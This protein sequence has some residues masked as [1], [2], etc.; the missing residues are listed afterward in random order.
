MTLNTLA[1]ENGERTD[2]DEVQGYHLPG[3]GNIIEQYDSSSDS[4]VLLANSKTTALASAYFAGDG[5]NSTALDLQ[6]GNSGNYSFDGA[7]YASNSPASLQ[8]H[9][10]GTVIASFIVKGL[11]MNGG[12]NITVGNPSTPI[13]TC[14]TSQYSL[15][16]WQDFY[17]WAN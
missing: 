11:T 9:T 7:I 15:I 12:S 10:S 13:L 14:D 8:G 2:A 1:N 3:N 5:G 4:W 17:R 16:G 6:G